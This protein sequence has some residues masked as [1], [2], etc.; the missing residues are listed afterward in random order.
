MLAV[1]YELLLQGEFD[2]HI[3]SFPTLEPRTN[4]LLAIPSSKEAS[5]LTF[6]ALP[7]PTL[8]EAIASRG[9]AFGAP[10]GPGVWG[11]IES[12]GG[13]QNIVAPWN[14]PDYMRGYYR[15]LELFKTLDPIVVVVDPVYSQ[16]LDA[17]RQ[18]SRKHIVLSPTSLKETAIHQQP[19]LAFIWKYPAYVSGPHTR[20][21]LLLILNFV[22]AWQWSSISV[23]VVSNASKH[24]H[25]H[26][27]NH[28]PSDIPSHQR[29][30]EV[31]EAKRHR[32]LLPLPRT[33][34]SPSTVHLSRPARDRFPLRH[35]H[36]HHDRRPNLTPRKTRLKNRPRIVRL[37]PAEPNR[38]D[39]PRDARPNPY[40]RC[41]RTRQ[42]PADGPSPSPKPPS[43]MEAQIQR[44]PGR[45]H[46]LHPRQRISLRHRAHHPLAHRRTPRA[47][48][49][50]TNRM[51]RQPRRR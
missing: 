7:G 29:A 36:K 16:G 27:I 40:R 33:L 38:L 39:Q 34:S 21:K 23:I 30:R 22:K 43:P 19:R 50:R 20:L 18:D 1:V 10:H 49:N 6:H 47:P 3:A 35:T 25:Q 2:V 46:H 14:G 31:P 9:D 41:P 15:C 5:N 28:Q 4:D 32:R 37:A 42:R 24:I 51:L 12:Y 11:A 13:I 8:T 45:R 48:P 44:T 26:P 17:C